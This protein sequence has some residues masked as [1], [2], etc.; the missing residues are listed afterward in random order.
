MSSTTSPIGK[1]ALQIG[2]SI[3]LSPAL[4]H[5]SQVPA[6][7]SRL[8]SD[9]SISDRVRDFD[10]RMHS[11]FADME[12]FAIYPVTPYNDEVNIDYSYMTFACERAAGSGDLDEADDD[13]EAYSGLSNFS[14]AFEF[15]VSEA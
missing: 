14:Y 2:A 3:V 5:A 7:N 9:V 15:D 10:G 13:M 4:A 8:A 1:Y 12:Q 6:L 11:L